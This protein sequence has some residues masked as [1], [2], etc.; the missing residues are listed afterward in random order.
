VAGEAEF[1]ITGFGNYCGPWQHVDV[2]GAT[3]KFMKINTKKIMVF[4]NY[5]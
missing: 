1:P 5:T 4:N 2:V 3:F